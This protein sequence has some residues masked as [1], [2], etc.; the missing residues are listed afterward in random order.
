MA[1]NRLGIHELVLTNYSIDKLCVSLE[2]ADA[3]EDLLS[4]STLLRQSTNQNAKTVYLN[5][6]LTKQQAAAAC[7]SRRKRRTSQHQSPMAST[8]FPTGRWSTV[9]WS[10][11]CDYNARSL[12][13]KFDETEL[14]FAIY[15]PD[16]C[17]SLR[18][19]YQKLFL[20][21]WLCSAPY[22]LQFS[23]LIYQPEVAVLH[24]SLKVLLF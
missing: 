22:R 15:R 6:D 3:V 9:F 8:S 10:L 19:G 4:S 2:N 7:K 1:Q 20:I 11:G 12:R 5:R 23:D 16:I 21:V 14:F 13:N 18:H 24:G 17:V